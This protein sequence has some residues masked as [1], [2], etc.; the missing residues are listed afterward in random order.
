[1]RITIDDFDIGTLEAEFRRLHPELAHQSPMEVH[2]LARQAIAGLAAHFRRA[3][4]DRAE[5]PLKSVL[6]DFSRN[7]DRV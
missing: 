7:L 4:I 1:M 2:A 5:N 6:D 3:A